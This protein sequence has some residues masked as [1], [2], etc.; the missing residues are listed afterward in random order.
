MD[1]Q[2]SGSTG[3][4]FSFGKRHD[5]EMPEVSELRFASALSRGTIPISFDT[6]ARSVDVSTIAQK[7]DELDRR[8]A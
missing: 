3:A 5:L 1:A 4:S 2:S 8:K 6:G 7:D